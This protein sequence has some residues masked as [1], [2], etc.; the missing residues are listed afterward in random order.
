MF[1]E[2]AV[3][4][5]SNASI[6]EADDYIKELARLY[7]DHPRLVEFEPVQ[8]EAR[9]IR[10]ERR[11]KKQATKR[12][13]RQPASP[14]ERMYLEAIS[15]E[16]INPDRCIA[17]L[18]AMLDLYN[19]PTLEKDQMMR[20]YLT[21]AIRKIDRIGKRIDEYASEHLVMLNGRVAYA[22]KIGQTNPDEAA[23]LCRA[24]IEL[25][26]DKTWAADVVARARTL[27]DQL[28]AQP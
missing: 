12:L 21:L 3:E 8:Q 9:F 23:G 15:Y 1:I 26:G 27:F 28:S 5:G 4:D 6:E 11:M 2:R 24:V 17:K 16:E 20:D 19:D 7:P 22:E 18:Q 13:R 10:L 25:Y 14:L